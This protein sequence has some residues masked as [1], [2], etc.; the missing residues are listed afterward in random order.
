M[1][2]SK[3]HPPL[4]TIHQQMLEAALPKRQLGMLG[5]RDP[6]PDPAACCPM[7][8]DDVQIFEAPQ[9]RQITPPL[10]V[11]EVIE[12]RRQIPSAVERRI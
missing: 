1:A 3:P 6:R 7:I 11:G 2:V 4:P 5:P 10:A 8:D 9:R 12:Q